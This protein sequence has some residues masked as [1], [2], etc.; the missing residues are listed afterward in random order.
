M[1]DSE[2]V[3]DTA[4]GTVLGLIVSTTLEETGV[5][6]MIER[7]ISEGIEGAKQDMEEAKKEM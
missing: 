5:Q 3:R 6:D 4:I 2:T 1:I 7:A